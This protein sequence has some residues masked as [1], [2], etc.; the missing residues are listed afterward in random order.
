MLRFLEMKLSN[1]SIKCIFRT[2]AHAHFKIQDL[3]FDI[4][5]E[6]DL[7]RYQQ[8]SSQ[9]I[10]L[11]TCQQDALP[12]LDLEKNARL[13]SKVTHRVE[14]AQWTNRHTHTVFHTLTDTQVADTEHPVNTHPHHAASNVA[15]PSQP[16]FDDPRT[17]RS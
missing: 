6:S 3:A 13:T 17:P 8:L 15:L 1:H 7:K 10:A 16:P 2:E 5:W 12:I 9:T 14:Q 11:P 4:S